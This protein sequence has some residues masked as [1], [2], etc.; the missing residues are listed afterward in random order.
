MSTIRVES[1]PASRWAE[2]KPI[3]AHLARVCPLRSFFVQ[4]DW[5]EMWLK[6]CTENLSATLLTFFDGGTAVGICILSYAVIRYGPIT[7]IRAFLNAA[8]EPEHYDTCIEYNTILC[9]AGKEMDV[10]DALVALLKEARWDELC[11]NGFFPS[12]I[13]DHLLAELTPCSIRIVEKPCHYVDL[14]VVRAKGD[15][16]AL[17]GRTTRE[18]LRRNRRE[19]TKAGEIA[20]HASRTVE[21]ALTMLEELRDLHQAS[22]RARGKLGAFAAPPFLAFHRDL[23][24]RTFTAGATKLLKIKAGDRVCLLYLFL[25]ERK[26]L[27]YQS[28]LQREADRRLSLGLLAHAQAVEWCLSNDFKEYDLLA[29]DSQYKRSLGTDSRS[30]RWVTVQRP[31]IKM[32]AMSIVRTLRHGLRTL[33]DTKVHSSLT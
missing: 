32:R 25:F 13:L 23:I 15:Y 9:L 3:W 4:A 20:T 22:W 7:I 26:V 1:V 5:T 11:L 14:D 28:G 19:Y 2:V 31:T 6:H 17:L 12:P 16:S 8:G 24:E 29:G 21:Q 33:W 27:F 18:R 30:L 10:A